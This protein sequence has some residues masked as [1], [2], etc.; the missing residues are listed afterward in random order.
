MDTS[1]V[2]LYFL[3][4]IKFSIRHRRSSHKSSRHKKE[5]I[6]TTDKLDKRSKEI[7]E[8]L[9]DKQ[10]VPPLEDRLWKHVPQED[11]VPVP[12]VESDSDHEPSSTVTIPTPPRNNETEE[13]ST[14]T[15]KS[16]KESDSD[17]GVVKEVIRASSPPKSLPDFIW[18]GTISMVDVAQISITAHE[19][20][21]KDDCIFSYSCSYGCLLL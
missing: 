19:V 12:N 16:D 21:G 2:T 4:I 10:I 8:Q 9:V 3:K 6:A 17:V 7:L 20:S 1:T 15:T 5:N 18:T 11:V 14:V 13:P